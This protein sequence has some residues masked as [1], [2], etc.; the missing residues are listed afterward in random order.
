MKLPPAERVVAGYVGCDSRNNGVS[1]LWLD[2]SYHTQAIGEKFRQ[3]CKE[4]LKYDRLCIQDALL[5]KCM[6][7]TEPLR[8][9]EKPSLCR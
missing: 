2:C 3:E 6:D 8:N 5:T 1:T 7:A 4:L 9:I